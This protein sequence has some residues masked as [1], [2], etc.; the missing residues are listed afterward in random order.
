MT[1]WAIV[2]SAG[3]GER[4]GT[5]KQF[6]DVAGERAV[7]RVVT[8]VTDV[9]DGTV[10]VLPRDHVWSGPPVDAVVVGGRSRAASVRAGL[11][12]VP[13]SAEVVLVHDA[14]HPLAPK[15]LFEDVLAAVLQGADA[16]VC[17]L[18]MTEVVQVVRDGCVVEVLPKAGQVLAQS[19]AAFRAPTLRS[20]HAACPE[21]TEDVELVLAAGAHVVA[22]P[23]DPINIHVTTPAEL[24]VARLLSAVEPP[25][26]PVRRT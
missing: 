5:R 13:P 11:S 16:A 3:G 1:T 10:L 17:V 18:P 26:T 23:G 9:V 12:E 22:V 2:L 8:T 4:F 25:G 7:D 20:A 6:L 15:R 19:P 21:A 24:E 14:A